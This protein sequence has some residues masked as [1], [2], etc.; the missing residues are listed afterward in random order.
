MLMARKSKIIQIILLI[1]LT[2]NWNIL[3]I[4]KSNANPIPVYMNYSGGIV[5]KNIYNCS[6]TDANVEINV[7]ALNVNQVLGH[8]NLSFIG[9][10]TIFNPS[11]AINITIALPFDWEN[12]T[13]SNM[14]IIANNISIPFVL[15]NKSFILTDDWDGFFYTYY[16]PI[17]FIVFNITIPKNESIVIKSSFQTSTSLDSFIADEVYINYIVGTYRGWSPH[18]GSS[19]ISENVE[20]RVQG[21][22]PDGFS[23]YAPGLFSR[24]CT[25]TD[26]NNGKS[27]LWRWDNETIMD[28]RVYIMYETTQPTYIF[29]HL[30][31]G[32]GLLGLISVILICTIISAKYRVNKKKRG[33]IKTT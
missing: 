32:L 2:F 33:I 11:D 31:L 18:S 16:Y 4:L 27:Y 14:E 22:Q 13:S 29:G 6:M 19:S 30:Y 15:V 10:Y 12:A 26:I 23:D 24:N 17:F 1:I 8:F 7:D 3:F 5:P 28:N 21:Q 9:N 20:F 25:V